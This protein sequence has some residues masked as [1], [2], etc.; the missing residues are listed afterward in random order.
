MD[1][2]GAITVTW[3][4]VVIHRGGSLFLDATAVLG[5]DRASLPIRHS[6]ILMLTFS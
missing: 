3:P 6:E 2:S 1:G 4:A 5:I